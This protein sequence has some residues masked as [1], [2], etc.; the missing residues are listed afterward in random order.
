MFNDVEMTRAPSQLHLHK[1]HLYTTIPS[2]WP[3]WRDLIIY[4]NTKVLTGKSYF[5]AR[6]LQK[7]LSYHR[8]DVYDLLP[9][10]FATVEMIP[11]AVGTWMVHCHVNVHI[12]GGMQALFTVVEPTSEWL[13]C[14]ENTSFVSII[15]LILSFTLVGENKRDLRVGLKVWTPTPLP[16]PPPPH[17]TPC[18]TVKVLIGGSR[19]VETSG[20]RNL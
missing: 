10:T 2:R 1:F 15:Y 17:W 9:E 3:L 11:D 5:I 13:K 8:G 16:P 20:F 6:I 12:T 4:A 7:S 18:N 19:F 14:C